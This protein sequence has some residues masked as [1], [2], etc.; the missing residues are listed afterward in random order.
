[1]RPSSITSVYLKHEAIDFYVDVLVGFL[2]VAELI[3]LHELLQTLPEVQRKKVDPHQAARIQ[4][5]LQSVQLGIQVR[6][7]D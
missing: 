7:R 4:D 3:D 6:T 1:M 2:R 5:Q